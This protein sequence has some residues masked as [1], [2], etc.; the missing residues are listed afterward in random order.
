MNDDNVSPRE[1]IRIWQESESLAEVA[2]RTGIAPIYAST[3]ASYY[4]NQKGV[5][6]KRFHRKAEDWKGLAEYAASFNGSE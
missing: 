6:L 5:P 2:K 3:R 4:R 1:F